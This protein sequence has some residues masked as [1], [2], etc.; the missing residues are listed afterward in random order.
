MM[1]K[2]G[3]KEEAKK[4]KKEMYKVSP[5][6]KAKEEEEEKKKKNCNYVSNSSV[7]E[8]VY[9]SIEEVQW[10]TPDDPKRERKTRELK[11][12]K[13]KINF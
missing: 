1:D 7:F 3:N 6:D 9:L 5:N 12:K 10:E 13:K 4:N 8:I 2:N 11:G